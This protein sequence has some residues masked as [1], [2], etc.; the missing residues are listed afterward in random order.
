[1]LEQVPSHE[2]IRKGDVV[3]TAGYRHAPLQS[4][5]PPGLPI[6]TVSSVGGQEPGDT[7]T[8]QVKPV[9]QPL[10]AV[11]VHRLRPVSAEANRAGLGG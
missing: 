2:P 5:Y 10:R 6:G 8:V 9:P 11:A 4:P 3:V 1:M 7:Q